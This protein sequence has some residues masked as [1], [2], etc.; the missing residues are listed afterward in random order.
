[1]IHCKKCRKEYSKDDFFLNDRYYK[2][3]NFCRT[4]R[5]VKKMD[6]LDIIK[7][8]IS[9]H[10][11]KSST[12]FEFVVNAET[13]FTEIVINGEC[14]ISVLPDST[15]KEIKRHIDKKLISLR[16]NHEGIIDDCVI[17][18]EPIKNNV[19]CPKCSNNHCG[20]CYINLFK[21]GKGII[22]CPF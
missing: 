18:F 17:C 3:C 11:D 20:N 21:S 8:L 13:S 10:Y 15:W 9:K 5:K 6:K 12:S 22:T 4:K 16:K 2:T 14:N 7:E 1:M 19:S